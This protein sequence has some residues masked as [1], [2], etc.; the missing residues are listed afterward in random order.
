MAE[1]TTKQSVTTTNRNKQQVKERASARAVG[2]LGITCQRMHLKTCDT[3]HCLVSL[4]SLSSCP[5]NPFELS[6][7]Y[8]FVSHSSFSFSDLGEV[9][10]LGFSKKIQAVHVLLK[11]FDKQWVCSYDIISTRSQLAWLLRVHVCAL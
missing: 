9:V 7:D 10:G 1:G 6:P 5:L 8:I 4:I 3:S 2:S 11:V